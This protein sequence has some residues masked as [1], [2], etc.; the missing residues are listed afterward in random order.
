MRPTVDEGMIGPWPAW[1]YIQPLAQQWYD[2]DTMPLLRGQREIT[3]L[4]GEQEPIEVTSGSYMT[5]QFVQGP[6]NYFL[7]DHLGNKHRVP[8]DE[9]VKWMAE[10]R[11]NGDM[12]AT[13]ACMWCGQE[14]PNESIEEHEAHCA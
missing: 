2:G 9:V 1:E 13:K 4:V 3:G 14:V 11:F 8:T 6:M 5:R 7:V 10:A 12:L